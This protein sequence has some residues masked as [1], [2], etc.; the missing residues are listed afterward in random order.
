MPERAAEIFDRA[1]IG[2]RVSAC[3]KRRI[4]PDAIKAPRFICEARPLGAMVVLTRRSMRVLMVPPEGSPST[5]MISYGGLSDG[6]FENCCRVR[7]IISAS[8]KTG[9]MMDI[10]SF[11][12]VMAVCP[13]FTGIDSVLH[14]F[15]PTVNSSRE[16]RARLFLLTLS[17]LRLYRNL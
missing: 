5:T 16:S 7:L 12:A 6:L 3:R 17:D 11:K 2:R 8:F 15:Y 4:P 13:L 1:P 10:C 9:M 14:E